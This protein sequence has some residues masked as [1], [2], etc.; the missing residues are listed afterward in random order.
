M[1]QKNII[2]RIISNPLVQTF[3]IYVSGGWIV[4]EMTDYIINKYSLNEKINDVLPIILLIG[5]PVTIFLAWYLSREKEESEEKEVEKAIDRKSQGIL[6]VLRNKPWFSI[7]GAVVLILLLISGIR[8]I[9]QQKMIKWATEQAIP[10]IRQLRNE[11]NYSAAFDLAQKAEKY[12]S[13]DPKFGE[14]ASLVGTKL[15]IITDPTDADVYTREYA[16]IDAEWK[17][18]GKTPIDSIKMPRHSFYLIKIV[19]EGY[20]NVLAVAPTSVDTLS[21]KLFEK[22]TIPPGMVYVDGYWDEVKNVFLEEENG[23]FMDRYEVTNKQFK[24]FVDHGGYRNPKYWKHEFIKKEKELTWEEAMAEFTDRTGRSGPVTWEASNYPEGQDDY[25]V[26][27]ISWYEAA[28]YSEYV[29]KSLPTGDHWDSGAGFNIY[30][31]IRYFNSSLIP[32]SN[33][34]RKGSEPVGISGGIN[35]Y[36]TFDMAGNVREW[37]WNETQNG[38]I[39]SGAAWDDPPYLYTIWSHLPPFDR[40]PKNGFRCVQYIDEEKTPESAFRFIEIGNRRDFNIE[41]PVSDE[42]FQFF[43][44]QFQY[45]KTDLH[46]LIEER[47]ENSKYWIKEKIS[48]DAC[49]ENERMIAYLFLPKQGKPPFQTLIFFPGSYALELDSLSDQYVRSLFDFLLNNNIA[50]MWPVYMGTIDRYEEVVDDTPNKSHTYTEYLVKWVKDFSRSMDYL[51]TRSDIDSEKIGFY[52]HSWGGLMGFIIP[53]IE[54]RLKL[55]VLEGGGLYSWSEAFPEADVIN[56]ITR[57]NI[58][59]LMLNGKH[60]FIFPLETDLKP[61]YELLGTPEQ[62]KVLML[63]DSDHNV[64]KTEVIKETLNWLD[65][66]FGPVNK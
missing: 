38:R 17:S 31:V 26:S 46:S 25:P 6:K 28:A 29:G 36:G 20:E 14:L 45:D 65:K 2:K 40:S 3:L 37:C 23:F 56:Y 53:A 66:Y 10:E 55:V 27:G 51:E 8:Y 32:F 7:P 48:F 44:T 49:Y 47:D 52:G 34:N 18:L 4:L 9:H 12:I 61:M 33:F 30:Y 54:E 24:E 21:R 11:L 22:G 39:I 15:T 13:E 1:A 57:I 35:C 16:E 42:L 43:K 62:D 63:Y 50:V 64:P 41:E 60:D 5:L 58:P 59:V 19:K